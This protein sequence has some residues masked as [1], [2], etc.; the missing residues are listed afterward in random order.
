MYNLKLYNLL[1]KAHITPPN[2][3]DPNEKYIEN[4]NGIPKA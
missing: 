1:V 4:A 2:I 3:Q